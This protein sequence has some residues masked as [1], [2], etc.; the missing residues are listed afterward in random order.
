MYVLSVLGMFVCVVTRAVSGFLKCVCQ[1]VK[2]TSSTPIPT[3]VTQHTTS[4]RNGV[5]DSLSTIL[6][7]IE[8]WGVEG[9]VGA[10]EGDWSSFF[11]YCGVTYVTYTLRLKYTK[12]WVWCSKEWCRN[13]GGLWTMSS[14][15][16]PPS[17]ES[18]HNLHPCPIPV[19]TA[20]TPQRLRLQ[21]QTKNE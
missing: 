18:P 14:S 9:Y 8:Y 2:P 1:C 20:G 12:V 3:Q 15:M 17:P 10:I 5:F 6:P 19:S 11:L 4:L 16:N 13:L 7:D 21:G